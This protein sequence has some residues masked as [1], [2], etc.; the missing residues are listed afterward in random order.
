MF[1][2]EDSSLGSRFT[3]KKC[4]DESGLYEILMLREQE[5]Q[6]MRQLKSGTNVG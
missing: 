5:K 6:E 2:W 1:C 3:T 4:T